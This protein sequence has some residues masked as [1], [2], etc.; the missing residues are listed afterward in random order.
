MK[1]ETFGQALRILMIDGRY[2]LSFFAGPG[3]SM[4]L[5]GYWIYKHK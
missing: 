5:A 4:L 1:H 3:I 2:M